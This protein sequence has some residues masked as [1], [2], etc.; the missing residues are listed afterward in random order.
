MTVETE[1]YTRQDAIRVLGIA[2]NRATYDMD[3]GDLPSNGTEGDIAM[4]NAVAWMYRS[5]GLRVVLEAGLR[6]LQN[7]GPFS[8]WLMTLYSGA[9]EDCR[10]IEREMAAH[11]PPDAEPEGMTPDEVA[12]AMIADLHARYPDADR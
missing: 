9:R 10:R 1:D 2:W 3:V 8:D 4:D 11:F 5:P 6:S 12:D 7:D